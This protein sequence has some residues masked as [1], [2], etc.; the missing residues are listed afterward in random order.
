MAIDDFIE[1]FLVDS[2]TSFGTEFNIVDV[3]IVLFWG[4]LLSFII[5]ITYRGT[6]SSVSYSYNFTQ[7]LVL[8]GLIVSVI[9]LIIG[10]NLARAFTLIGALSI[11]RFRSA[12]KDARDLGFI[13]F[14]MAMG[15]AC[16]TRFYPIAI[17]ITIVGCLL[18]Y[19]MKITKF[20][21]KYLAQD[22]L[23]MNLPKT[24]DY[25]DVLTSIF[26]QHLKYYSLLSI[27]SIDE[28]RN[29]LSFVITFKS[30]KLSIIRKRRENFK[31]STKIKLSLISKIQEK[32]FISDMKL[33][34]GNTAEEL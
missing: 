34:E 1:K 15:M 8:L 7:N 12:I 26:T 32:G 17:M 10:S 22:L 28:K 29:R 25:I 16:G 27:S 14:T 5:A 24:K 18:M 11:V 31:E 9:M 3:I 13:F 30:P 23:E 4:I 33:I 19:F 21:Q 20:G 6:H 2:F